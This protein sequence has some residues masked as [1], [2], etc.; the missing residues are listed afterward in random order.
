MVFV[1]VG[2]AAFCRAGPQGVQ[3][4]LTLAVLRQ[5]PGDSYG[6]Y[7]SFINRGLFLDFFFDTATS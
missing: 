5:Y 7:I 4:A 6:E 3:D 1:C 2:G